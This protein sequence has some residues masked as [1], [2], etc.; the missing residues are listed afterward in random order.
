MLLIDSRWLLDGIDIIYFEDKKRK[1]MSL[2][3][4]LMCVIFRQEKS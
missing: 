3:S 4:N 2:L 1:I